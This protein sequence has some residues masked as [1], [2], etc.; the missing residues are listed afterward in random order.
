MAPVPEV[1]V[2]MSVFNGACYLHASIDSVL[3]QEGVDFEFIIVNDG[4]T[5]ETPAILEE[6]AARDPR[7]RIIHQENQGL[8]KALIRGCAEARGEFI[9]RQDADDLSLP[10]RLAAQVELLRSDDSLVFVSSWAEV[11]GPCDEPL[12]LY[13]RPSDA[14]AATRLLLEGRTGPPG[15]GSV[16]F[17]RETYER[18]G[19]YRP[20]LYYAQDSDLWLRF[21]LVGR[22]NYVPQL[23]YQYR[24]AAESISGLMHPYKVAFAEIV[25]ELH[26]A[27]LAG[28]SESPI[29]KW[30]RSLPIKGSIGGIRKSSVDATSYFI[31]RCL[32]SRSDGRALGYFIDCLRA[33]P[34]FWRAWLFLPLAF[35]L[36]IFS[37]QGRVDADSFCC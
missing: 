23:L 19:G 1:S 13:R 17:R 3:A 32:F 24:I 33:N 27:R 9:A 7:I 18:V 29:L 31:G 10:G 11:I 6:Y 15:H 5:D 30:A 37:R 4:S 34:W 2:V 28:E 36:K 26:A 22:L 14:E 12:L 25:D 21:G 35:V 20:E 16:M 8:T